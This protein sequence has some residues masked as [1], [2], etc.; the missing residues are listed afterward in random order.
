MDTAAAFNSIDLMAAIFVLVCIILGL[1]RGL[2]GA[3][4]PIVG[5]IV[6]AAAVRFG[7]PP[8]RDWLVAH[9][10]FDAS[11]L[12]LGAVAIVIGVPLVAMI[13]LR[14]FLGALVKLPFI[15]GI[16]RLG[17]AL[18]GLIGGTVFV[19]AAFLVLGLLP[20]RYQS[21]TVHEASWIGRHMAILEEDVIGAVTQKVSRTESAILKARENRA[22]RREKWEQ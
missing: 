20:Q 8:C 10:D 11:V 6:I 18:A 17:G 9:L 16:D 15:S 7:Y 22:G 13:G 3:I 12:R 5:I 19:I 21:P 14:K 1:R 4:A 2:I